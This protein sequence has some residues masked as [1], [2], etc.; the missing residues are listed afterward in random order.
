MANLAF[1]DWFKRFDNA[2]QVH[3]YVTDEEGD[4]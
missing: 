2:P 3:P 1:K 4:A